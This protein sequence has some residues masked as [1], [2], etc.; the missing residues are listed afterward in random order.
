MRCS[1]VRG[2][3]LVLASFAALALGACAR[4]LPPPDQT[5]TVRGRIDA[6]PQPPAPLAIHHELIP[7]F[8]D[9]TG[10]V[11]G[12]REMVMD[13]PDLAPGVSLEGLKAGDP[14]E[15]TFEVRWKSDPRA[16]VTRIVR[17]PDDTTLELGGEREAPPGGSTP[18]PEKAPETTP[19]PP[20]PAEPG[21]G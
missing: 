21:P 15:F 19:D 5:Y 12:M 13:F 20:A 10:K 11:V 9:R 3:V 14:I 2:V 8:L 1:L 7:E 4:E 6:L 16:R 17:L 18:S